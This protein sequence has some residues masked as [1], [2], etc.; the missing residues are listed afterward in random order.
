MTLP[1]RTLLAGAALSVALSAAGTVSAWNWSRLG[2]DFWNAPALREQ[3]R[4]NLRRQAELDGDIAQTLHNNRIREMILR[5]VVAGRLSVRE[6]AVQF[7][8][9][10]ES[11][12]VLR[13]A[14]AGQLQRAYPDLSDEERLYRHVI[15]QAL[16]A[17]TSDPAR[18]R[19]LA[20]RL[21]ASLRASAPADSAETYAVSAEG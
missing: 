17:C 13:D 10:A 5:E 21:E 16:L 7:A 1:K 19:V 3:V 11:Q 15:D 14:F 6:A 2:L 9:L 18:A 4:T 8:E 12:P 20:E